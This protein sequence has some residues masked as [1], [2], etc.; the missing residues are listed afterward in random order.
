MNDFPALLAAL[1]RPRPASAPPP[2][3]ATLVSVAGSSYRRPGARLVVTATGQRLG[4]ISG[5]CLEEDVLARAQRVATTRRPEL[6]TYDTSAENDLVWG[7]GLGCHGVVQ[8]LLE[9]IPSPAPEWVATVSANLAARRPTELAVVWQLPA[10]APPF[11]LGTYLAAALPPDSAPVNAAIFRESLRPPPS[12]LIFGAGDDA[13]PLAALA[14]QLGWHVTVADPRAAFATAARFPSADRI[15]VA[16]AAELVARLAPEPAALAVVMTHHYV[17][18]VPLLRDLLP[19]N[20]S[21]LGLLGPKKRADRIL[22]DLARDGLTLNSDQVS[23]LHAPV[24]LDL[25][26]ERPAE[27]ALAILAEMQAALTRR[28]AR[29][30]RERTRPIHD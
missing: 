20:L 12:L 24:G 8:V 1:A 14:S 21:Y 19:L 10:S 3:L 22:A 23:R 6:V 11:A 7:V 9:P 30:L 4:S 18:D 25:G 13:Q 2:V 27:V 16:P 5:G 28:N 15:V 17:H 29:P 26:A